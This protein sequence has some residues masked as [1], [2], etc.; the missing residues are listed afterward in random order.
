MLTLFCV[1]AL[2]VSQLPK[3]LCYQKAYKDQE[4]GNTKQGN[5]SRN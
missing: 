1:Y 4:L 5:L 2:R 3:A